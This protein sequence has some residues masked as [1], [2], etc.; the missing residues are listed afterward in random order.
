MNLCQLRNKR[1]WCPI[2]QAIEDLR[3]PIRNLLEQLHERID[4][5][6]YRLIVGGDASGRIPALIFTKVIREIYRNKGFD[7]PQTLT[8]FIAGGER[9][10]NPEEKR[11]EIKAHIENNYVGDNLGQIDISIIDKIKS[12]L[13]MPIS[14]YN[15]RVLIIEDTICSGISIKPVT[16]TL[17]S[18]NVDYDIVSMGLDAWD[19]KRVELKKK[20]GGE[21]YH[22]INDTPDIYGKNSLAGVRKNRGDLSSEPNISERSNKAREDVQMVADEL[23]IWY[24]SKY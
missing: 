3:E 13:G 14:R 2:E 6:D 21:I 10:N 23:T 9:G 8:T 24:L 12:I 19:H 22:A 18:M 4:A 1:T 15:G 5:G 7:I 17:R 16:D 20:L 11:S